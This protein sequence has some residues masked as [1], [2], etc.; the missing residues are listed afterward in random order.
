V[1]PTLVSCPGAP[2]YIVQQDDTPNGMGC[3]PLTVAAISMC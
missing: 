3:T 1:V 2:T